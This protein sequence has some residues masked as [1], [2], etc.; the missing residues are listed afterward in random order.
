MAQDNQQTAPKYGREYSEKDSLISTTTPDSHITYA[1]EIFCK[2]AG[3]EQEELIGKPHNEVRHQ[4]MPKAAFAQ[5]WSYI[6]A[7]N[8]WM[9]LVK[10]Q[11][12]D[13]IEHYWVTA[14][15]TPIKDRDGNIIEYQSVRTKPTHGEVDRAEKAYAQLNAGKTGIPPLRMRYSIFQYILALIIFVLSIY[16]AA[17]SA[18]T[19][20]TL[21]ATM[22]ITSFLLAYVTFVQNR[23]LARI[24]SFARDA[25][26][27]PLMEKIYTN[28]YDD[29][30]PLE[31]SFRMRK[32]ELRAVVARSSETTTSILDL[33]EN[34][35]AVAQGIKES[36]YN[37]SQETELVATAVT[38][39]SHSIRE[40]AGN[41]QDASDLT[42]GANEAATLGRDKVDTT[43]NAVENLAEELNTAKEVV[44]EVAENSKQ[45]ESILEVIG[46]IAEQTNLLALNAAIEAARAGEAGRGFAVVAD[47]VRNLA[48]KTQTSTDEVHAMI[49]QLKGSTESAVRTMEKGV[50]LSEQCTTRA[51]ETGEAFETIADMLNKITDTSHHIAAAVEEQ[52]SV[53]EEIDRNVNNIKE[54]A[55]NTVNTSEHSVEHTSQLVDKLQA[56]DR[57]IIQFNR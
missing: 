48:S 23:R 7:G 54:L 38:E 45:I 43:I 35:Y 27:N 16:E 3:Y 17:T 36:I 50:E 52:A 9:G 46:A 51:N 15:V 33:A 28:H 19:N 11:C 29:F 13:S 53:T 10:N 20:M 18:S 5:L 2:I 31:L 34:Q 32:A 24:K 55:E 8:S 56:L 30:S 21:C 49:D 12:K 40:V 47:E 22:V 6:Q 42:R 39:M 14:F 1:N 41:A 26:N 4:S 37:Q 25:Y 44:A 57:L